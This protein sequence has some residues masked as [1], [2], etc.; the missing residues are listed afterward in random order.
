MSRTTVVEDARRALGPVGVFLPV[1]PTPPHI[2]LQRDAVR[3]F[4]RAGYG[5]AWTNELVGSKDALVQLAVLLAAT[6]RMAF[7]TGIA[8]IWAR[9]PQ[10]A[11]GAATLLAQAFPHRFVLALGVGHPH[12]AASVGREY[13][14]PLATMREYLERMTLPTDLPAPDVAYPLITGAMGPR[15]LAL[16]AE[17][18]DGAMPAMVS[19]EFTAQAREALGPDKLLAV[20][21]DVSPAQGDA[22][23]VAATVRG[24]LA[25]GADHVTV[26]MPIGTDFT[27]GVDHLE[28]LAPAVLTAD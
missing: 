8:N 26:G 10:T 11:H 12:Q 19:P 18:T 22:A 6:E 21:V 3:R 2:D 1:S 15:M 27:T 4:E 20:L 24:H 13:G 5:A 16:A 28:Q 14:K 7:A 9:P 23:T 17:L 25:A